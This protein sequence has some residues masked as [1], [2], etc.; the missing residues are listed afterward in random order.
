[1]FILH[2]LTANE[3]ERN[4]PSPTAFAADGAPTQEHTSVAGA[5][6]ATEGVGTLDVNATITVDTTPKHMQQPEASPISK[7]DASVEEDEVTIRLPASSPTSPTE[8]QADA[9]QMTPKNITATYIEEYTLSLHP[10]E[11]SKTLYAFV[12]QLIQVRDNLSAQLTT[13]QTKYEEITEK[14]NELQDEL[15]QTSLDHQ[16][17][18]NHCNHLQETIDNMHI[19]ITQEKLE[20]S[21][22]IEQLEQSVEDYNDLKVKYEELISEQ[23]ASKASNTSTPSKGTSNQ[24]SLLFPP[25]KK[26]EQPDYMQH[27]ESALPTET[28][29]FYPIVRELKAN[30]RLNVQ[31]NLGRDK[32]IVKDL[33]SLRKYTQNLGNLLKQ[34]GLYSISEITTLDLPPIPLIDQFKQKWEKNPKRA[35]AERSMEQESTILLQTLKEKFKFHSILKQKLEVIEK[36]EKL[37]NKLKGV[38]ALCKVREEYGHSNLESVIQATIKIMLSCL[39]AGGKKINEYNKF[40]DWLLAATRDFEDFQKMYGIIDFKVIWLANTYLAMKGIGRYK[41]FISLHRLTWPQNLE[42]ILLN[43]EDLTKDIIESCIKWDSGLDKEPTYKAR[44][45]G[46]E[47]SSKLQTKDLLTF[48]MDGSIDDEE[49]TTLYVDKKPTEC[50]YCHQRSHLRADCAN[51]RNDLSLQH[52]V[53]VLV[54]PIGHLVTEIKNAKKLIQESNPTKQSSELKTLN[55]KL[56]TFEK[57]LS[58]LM[59]GGTR[60]GNQVRDARPALPYGNKGKQDKSKV[61]LSGDKSQ[62]NRN[63]DNRPTPRNQTH[64]MTQLKSKSTAAMNLKTSFKSTTAKKS[65]HFTRFAT[66]TD[67]DEEEEESCFKGETFM[68]KHTDSN[69]NL[70]KVQQGAQINHEDPRILLLTTTE[71]LDIHEFRDMISSKAT[72]PTEIPDSWESLAEDGEEPELYSPMNEI[73]P[74]E[75][76]TPT[77]TMDLPI[78]K[79]N[80]LTPVSP[81]SMTQMREISEAF[82]RNHITPEAYDMLSSAITDIAKGNGLGDIDEIQEEKVTDGNANTFQKYRYGP[83]N[84]WMDMM[85]A[86]IPAYKEYILDNPVQYACL[87]ASVKQAHQIK[88]RDVKSLTMHKCTGSAA[89]LQSTAQALKMQCSDYLEATYNL[90]RLGQNVCDNTT[91]SDMLKNIDPGQMHQYFRHMKQKTTEAGVLEA[92]TLCTLLQVDIAFFQD[93]YSGDLLCSH[94]FTPQ[95]TKPAPQA[96]NMGMNVIKILLKHGHYQL[97]IA[98]DSE[99]YPGWGILPSPL[100]TL[101]CLMRITPNRKA[102]TTYV[103]RDIQITLNRIDKVYSDSINDE[104]ADMPGLIMS[105]SEDE[106]DEDDKASIDDNKTPKDLTP[107]VIDKETDPQLVD[108]D[109]TPSAM[110]PMG[111]IYDDLPELVKSES[112]DDESDDEAI[113]TRES[114]GL[115]AYPTCEKT[116][117]VAPHTQVYPFCGIDHAIMG[118]AIVDYKTEARPDLQPTHTWNGM[119]CISKEPTPN[120]PI[121]GMT[122]LKQIATNNTQAEAWPNH[123]KAFQQAAL[124]IQR[125]LITVMRQNDLMD[126]EYKDDDDDTILAKHVSMHLQQNP[127]QSLEGTKDSGGVD[128]ET[129]DPLFADPTITDPPIPPN[130]SDITDAGMEHRIRI[131]RYELSAA[132]KEVKKTRNMLRQEQREHEETSLQLKNIK[133][134]SAEADRNMVSETL[135]ALTSQPTDNIGWTINIKYISRQEGINLLRDLTSLFDGPKESIDHDL[136]TKMGTRAARNY[137]PGCPFHNQVMSY[138]SHDHPNRYSILTRHLL[139]KT[140]FTVKSNVVQITGDMSST[141][142]ALTLFSTLI[143]ARQYETDT[144]KWRP[145]RHHE[146]MLCVHDGDIKNENLDPWPIQ[147]LRGAIALQIVNTARRHEY[148][149][150]REEPKTSNVFEMLPTMGKLGYL[151]AKRSDKNYK[152][153]EKPNKRKDKPSPPKLQTGNLQPASPPAKRQSY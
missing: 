118:G 104:Y 145:E 113:D 22:A 137:L 50:S 79:A 97:I 115:C 18:E 112:E 86:K 146:I 27:C 110:D 43:A 46:N 59:L 98:P 9:E 116:I 31:Q 39:S 101:H 62:Q 33:P 61:A 26:P 82:E 55:E 6:N 35:E 66:M 95:G 100:P 65:P 56:S 150:R 20:H 48:I 147:P 92:L 136:L 131:L 133:I 17:C 106:S 14:Y 91:L 38:A 24:S 77:T 132:R 117:H 16:Q 15:N 73:T 47:A 144:L 4:I 58:P 7:D 44:R 19:E 119:Y 40:E 29:T 51:L 57:K 129:L 130:M 139:M 30:E 107:K 37:H 105:D 72:T 89:D 69:E 81:W 60:I 84:V 85:V 148:R 76:F 103:T 74:T 125:Q 140:T 13:V 149:V 34:L 124:P 25:L 52:K 45:Y 71:T 111:N 94:Y 49:K 135:T 23:N 5:I 63:D 10:D 114:K 142:I 99:I 80:A 90:L 53:A 2:E 75:L 122:R 134:S 64:T 153:F 1:M 141:T 28:D 151:P 11:H 109:P 41:Q 88:D 32:T 93:T 121:A 42:E 68:M 143:R 67:N 8:P 152:G 123:T 126:P 128:H 36:N 78:E 83:S 138:V 87:Y 70:N 54:P 96:R 102:D 21:E 108:H 12:E 3:M 120:T 127:T